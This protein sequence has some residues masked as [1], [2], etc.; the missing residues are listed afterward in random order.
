MTGGVFGIGRPFKIFRL[1][2]WVNLIVIDLYRKGLKLK[3]WIDLLY[4]SVGASIL[5]SFVCVYTY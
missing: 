4:N 3:R 2:G 1:V 5:N